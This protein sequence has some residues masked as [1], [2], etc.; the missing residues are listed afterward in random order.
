[1]ADLVGDGRNALP[2]WQLDSPI[3]YGQ[4]GSCF[5]PYRLQT[6]NRS[7]A[8]ESPSPKAAAECS[9]F[10]LAPLVHL[11]SILVEGHRLTG[12]IRPVQL[13]DQAVREPCLAILI[14]SERRA[15]LIPALYLQLAGPAQLTDDPGRVFPDLR[16]TRW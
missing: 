9:P 16:H 14:L 11:G 4:S 5:E 7:T 10:Q 2:Q 3:K 6:H 12:P 8:F 1:M 15:H 13:A